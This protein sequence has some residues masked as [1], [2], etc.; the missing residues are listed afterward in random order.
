MIALWQLISMPEDLAR[1]PEVGCCVS[2]SLLHCQWPKRREENTVH[3]FFS[4]QNE[5][6][7]FINYIKLRVLSNWGH[8]DYTCVYQFRLHGNPAPDGEAK[9]KPLGLPFMEE[10]PDL[11]P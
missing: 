4:L 1:Q 9:G 5:H 8:P 3:F 6:S 10:S 2:V 7:G 11:S